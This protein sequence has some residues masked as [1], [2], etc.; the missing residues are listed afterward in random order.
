MLSDEP[1][2][3]CCLGRNALVDDLCSRITQCR[4]PQVFGVFGDWGC[5]KTSFLKHVQKKL[6]SSSSQIAGDKTEIGKRPKHASLDRLTHVLWFEAWR[7]GSE[8]KPVVALL[9]EIRR[10]LRWSSDFQ[11]KA[12]GV[13]RR[14]FDALVKGGITT[15]ETAF[16]AL[17][18]S[19]AID[20]STTDLRQPYAEQLPVDLLRE[21]LNDSIRTL[22]AA[23]CRS[24]LVIIID[25][26]D[27]CQAEAAMRLLEGIKIYLNLSNCVFVLGLNAREVQRAIEKHIPGV[28]D[29]DHKAARAAEYLEKICA[30]TVRIPYP[31][32]DQLR[33]LLKHLWAEAVPDR[34]AQDFIEAISGWVCRHRSLPPNARKIKAWVN[35]VLGIAWQHC[36]ILAAISG[37]INGKRAAW[38][39]LTAEAGRLALAASL[40]AFH[41]ELYR[42]LQVNSM[43]IETLLI[44]AAGENFPKPESKS[45]D[46]PATATGLRLGDPLAADLNRL[47]RTHWNLDKSQLMTYTPAAEESVTRLRTHYDPSLPNVFHCQRLLVAIDPTPKE[48]DPWFPSAW[49]SSPA[50]LPS[51]SVPA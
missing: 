43:A 12:S 31:S 13:V 38:A 37:D 28:D 30:F 51:T 34:M 8:D 21:Q 15:A 33:I 5:G 39:H 1:S 3:D 50:Q 44:W 17:A 14:Y 45:A 9:Q 42:R 46:G 11:A 18:K 32:G 2:T 26:L 20:V 19:V 36:P 25:D 47:Q 24:R 23:R 22:L 10:T 16:T 35:A 29:A 40:H 48:I 7:Y 6:D 41:P 49:D 27:R 4:P